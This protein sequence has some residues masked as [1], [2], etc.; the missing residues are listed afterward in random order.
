M[1]KK[2]RKL[3]TRCLQKHEAA[4]LYRSAQVAASSAI[5][6]YFSFKLQTSDVNLIL[7]RT[8]KYQCLAKGEIYIYIYM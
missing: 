6:A 2:I 5:V 1:W 4:A 7:T 8:T 3:H